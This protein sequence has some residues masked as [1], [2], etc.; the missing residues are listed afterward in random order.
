MYNHEKRDSDF[1]QLGASQKN[2]WLHRNSDIIAHIEKWKLKKINQ[3][4]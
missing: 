1:I 3:K 2:T 4:F